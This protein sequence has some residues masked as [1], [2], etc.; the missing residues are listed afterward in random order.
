MCLSQRRHSWGVLLLAP[1]LAFSGHPLLTL[2]SPRAFGPPLPPSPLLSQ[3]IEAAAKTNQLAEVERVTRET[4]IYDPAAVKTFLME[5]KLPDAR[6]LIN[7]CD[8]FDFVHDLTHYLYT[9]NMMR[10]IEAYVQK[11]NPAKTPQV[12]GGLLDVECSEEFIKGLILSVRSLLPVEPLVDECEK[13]NRLKLLMPFL[14]HLVS[15]GSQDPHVHNAMGKIMV[16]SNNNPEHFLTTN[17]YY[18]ARV[19][20]KHCEKRDPLLACIAYK[21]GKCDAELI[22]CTSRNSLFKQQSR[23]VV[24]RADPDLWAT[25]LSEE[26]VHRRQLIDQ[27]VGTALPEVKNPELVSITVKAFM[28]AD[29]PNELIEL[30][31]KIVLQNSSFSSNPNLQN[32]LILTAI[33]ADKVRRGGR[34]LAPPLA[35]GSRDSRH[36]A[37]GAF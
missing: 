15:E 25:V 13:R 31:E 2:S 32:L 36:S 11:V 27:V 18:D 37:G 35:L 7:V 34:R 28:A 12:V 17:P 14:E 29:M 26:N 19:L 21:R 1:S 9:N 4:S 16:D 10:Y 20:G 5:A 8:R 23:Y 24:E 6:P 30:L 33:K 3:Y 22:D